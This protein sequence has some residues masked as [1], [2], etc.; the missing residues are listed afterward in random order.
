MFQLSYNIDIEIFALFL[1]V[2]L[3][4][5]I[6]YHFPQNT[7][8]ARMFCTMTLLVIFTELFD[9]ASAFTNTESYGEQIPRF[10]NLVINSGYY[11]LGFVLCYMLHYYIQTTFVPE[12]GKTCFPR[13]NK[14]IL[15]ATEISYLPNALAGFYFY[16]SPEGHYIHGTLYLVQHLIS[17]W[18]VACASLTLII[19]YKVI[20]KER[21]VSGF[22]FIFMYLGAMFLQVVIIPNIF[23][24]MPTVSIMLVLAA[25]TLES[26]DYAELQKTLEELSETKKNLEITNRKLAERAYIDLMTGLKNHA[27][28]DL[29]IDA[30]SA[31]ENR[32]NAIL[33]MAD[34]NGLKEL[35]DYY[36]HLVGD[37]FIIRT[38]KLI[39]ASFGEICQCYR[40]GGDEF[41]VIAADI[42]KE[43]FYACCHRFEEAAEREQENATYRFSVAYGYQEVGGLSIKEAQKKADENMY[44]NKMYKK[45]RDERM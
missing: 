25:F 2:L 33:L 9:M 13:A 45:E 38:A 14:W 10:I 21:F 44:A 6:R 39:K 16:I 36:G 24:I 40:I 5:Q 1:T 12:G 11:M 43:E 30:L 27:S 22:I 8:K 42:P 26:P 19:N 31:S 18:F 15:I 3:Y 17:F 4:Y 37:D 41:A 28:F 34:I 29:E 20:K 7:K 23:I 35:N 32:K